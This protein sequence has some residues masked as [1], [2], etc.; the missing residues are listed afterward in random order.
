MWTSSTAL[1]GLAASAV[2]A[3]TDPAR[4]T[5]RALATSLLTMA[6]LSFRVVVDTG[7]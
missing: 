6:S 1:T 3:A 2:D 7:G 5:P 4:V